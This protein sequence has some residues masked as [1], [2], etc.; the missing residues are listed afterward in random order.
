MWFWHPLKEEIEN[1]VEVKEK[2]FSEKE[3]QN[4]RLSIEDWIQ[5]Y[6][7]TD[8]HDIFL[9][10]FPSKWHAWLSRLVESKTSTHSDRPAEW[11]P[12]LIQRLKRTNNPISRAVDFWLISVLEGFVTEFTV[13]TLK[14]YNEAERYFLKGYH[15]KYLNSLS[16]WI[17]MLLCEKGILRLDA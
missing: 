9:A 4:P 7:F 13:D 12:E 16:L 8:L 14:A 15:G 3:N 11:T 17:K 2:E 1:W 5:R 10:T 6:I